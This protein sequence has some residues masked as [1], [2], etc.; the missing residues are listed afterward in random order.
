MKNTRNEFSLLWQ[1]WVGMAL[2]LW[3]S[4]WLAGCGGPAMS[5]Q[6][7]QLAA[8]VQ[9]AARQNPMQ[10]QLMAQV[11]RATL[12]GYQD[13][14]VGPEDLLDVAFMNADDLD[15]EVRVNG[16]GEISLPLVGSVKVSGMSPQAIEKRLTQLYRDGE[17]IK[18]PQI[19]VQVKEFRFQRVMV[20]GAVKIPG[21]HEV[22]GP[23]TL[24]EMLGKAGGLTEKAGSTVQVIRSQ[25]ASEVRKTLKRKA[26]GPFSPGSETIVVDLN[27]LLGQGAV[28]LNIPIQNGDVINVPFAQDAYVL[29][30]VTTPKN[31]PVRDNITA[32]QAVAMAG[33]QHL[34]LSSN[35]VTVVR[36]NAQ[37]GTDTLNLNIKKVTNGQEADI[38]LKGGDIVF[39]QESTIRRLM[40]D[41]KNLFPGS[42]SMGTAAAF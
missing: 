23:R 29:G 35:Q 41:F 38:P 40:Y 7:A 14:A 18:K 32:T 21:S 6:S 5:P 42:Y 26:I 17:Y 31:V 39:V 20:T 25:S 33:G 13:Y 24:L 28:E 4:V 9:A 1:T 27:R 3:V 8:Q 10:E 12:T 19:S 30:A 22:I 11:S 34:M 36:L 15:R 16:Q 2:L 37:G